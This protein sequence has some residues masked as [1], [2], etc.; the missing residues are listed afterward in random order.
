MPMGVPSISW[1]C[2]KASDGDA[3]DENFVIWCGLS[4]VS[5]RL[6]NTVK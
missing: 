6:H 1:V 5:Y 3:A 2:H 4:A